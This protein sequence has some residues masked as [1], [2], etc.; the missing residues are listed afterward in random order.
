MADNYPGSRT[1]ALGLRTSSTSHRDS[2]VLV[3]AG[4]GAP[5]GAT[6]GGKKLATGQA[7][8][9][10]RQDATSADAYC[11]FT[12]D[13]GTNWIA[14]DAGTPDLD[15]LTAAVVD[16]SADSFALIDAD[17]GNASKKDTI[18]DLIAAIAGAGLT[19]TSGVLSAN[20]S[21][22]S[23]VT[24]GT[25][26]IDGDGAR[27]NGGGL[28]GQV[29][30]TPAADYCK[31][32]DLGTTTWADVDN[33]SSLTGWTADYQLTADAA[34][35][36]VGDLFAIGF[37]VPVAEIAFD[38]SQLA[39]WGA[40]GMKY[41]YSDGP[42]STADLTLT[43]QTGPGID[44]TDSTAYNG[45]RS[46]Q[47]VGAITFD[48]PSDWVVDTIDGQEAYWIIGEITA[49]QVTQEPILNSKLPEAVTG[50]EPF[51]LPFD[52]TLSAVT[53]TDYASTLHTA[54]DVKICFLDRVSGESRTVTFAQ[55]RR[56]ERVTF[57]GWA[58][59]TAARIVP[60]VVQ[61]DG[62]NEALDM[63]FDFVIT[64]A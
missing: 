19:A 55:D 35:E 33:S 11:Y 32:Y 61:E 44:N 13:G 6:N 47:R 28:V 4:N 14:V 26:A 23:F 2:E 43:G 54:Q 42:G 48:P 56:R 27:T 31:V 10:Y 60:Y 53:M 62:T 46:L 3:L 25:M 50:E 21:I 36:Q 34:N 22:V 52:G 12:I 15:A 49:A 18:A 24:P 8:V 57:T 64:P 51:R 17:D 41:T 7:A 58:L 20:A 59:T 45:K 16:V 40:D 38:L 1:L 29:V 5:S 9:Y 30:A 37:D 63:R 39:T